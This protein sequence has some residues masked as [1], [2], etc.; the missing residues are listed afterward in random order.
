M[1]Q[2]LSQHTL[3]LENKK[4]RILGF[5]LMEEKHEKMNKEMD[6]KQEKINLD[7]AKKLF[8]LSRQ[9][10]NEY[11]KQYKKKQNIKRLERINFTKKKFSTMSK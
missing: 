5:K 8:D 11:I 1:K 6:E 9:Q 7:K 4:R 10:E 3:Y 2:S